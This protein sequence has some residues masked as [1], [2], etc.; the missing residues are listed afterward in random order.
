MTYLKDDLKSYYTVHGV[1]SLYIESEKEITLI[2]RKMYRILVV[3]YSAFTQKSY[4]EN[5]EHN[6]K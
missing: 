1:A 6:K 3:I 2:Q 4:Q 5:Y